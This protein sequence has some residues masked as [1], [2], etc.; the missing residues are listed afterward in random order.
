MEFQEIITLIKTVSDSNITNL[1]VEQG[2]V[3]I[4][5]EKGNAQAS[6]T[7]AVQTIVQTKEEPVHAPVADGMI[8]KSPLVGIF[9]SAPTPEEEPFVKVGDRI[10]KGQTLAII[11]AM[12][13]MNEVESEYTGVIEEVYVQNEEMIEYGQPL[14][15]IK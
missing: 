12:K 6:Y 10:E 4:S 9:Y 7:S 8:V 13:L 1:T 3:K 2:G 14:F 15:L 11:E 5:M